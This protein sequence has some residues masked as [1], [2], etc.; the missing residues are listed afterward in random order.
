MSDC[1]QI[2]DK[3]LKYLKGVHTL[4]MSKRPKTFTLY[5]DGHT[6]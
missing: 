2:T 3:T 6:H 5:L 4:D 1:D